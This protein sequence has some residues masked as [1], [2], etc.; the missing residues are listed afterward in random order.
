MSP[1]KN[2]LTLHTHLEANGSLYTAVGDAVAGIAHA[3]RGPLANLL[4]LFEIVEALR[5]RTPEQ[6]ATPDPLV[7]RMVGLT[8]TTGEALGYREV[9][10]DVADVVADAIALCRPLAASR[11]VAVVCDAVA[12]FCILGDGAL[13][14][15]ALDAMFGAA[16]SR[17][18]KNGEVHLALER[19]GSSVAITV[20][21]APK[22]PPLARQQPDD[23]LHARRLW[24]A[25]LI[26]IRHGGELTI[27]G[28]QKGHDRLVLMLP[29]SV[30]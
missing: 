12:P 21:Y 26:A 22:G 17:S 19:R 11:S 14:T 7:S 24:L 18:A 30:R 27:T 9:L 13:L 29:A 16:I 28:S 15:E 25:R 1:V 3:M 20:R 5:R 6:Q 2:T 4:I 10:V 8:R 23:P